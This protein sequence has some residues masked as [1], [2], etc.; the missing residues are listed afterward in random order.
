ME[1]R[2]RVDVRNQGGQVLFYKREYVQ[3]MRGLKR[4]RTP[5]ECRGIVV[6]FKSDISLDDGTES[7]TKRLQTDGNTTLRIGG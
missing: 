1:K 7:K 5:N 3:G 6:I 4:A 2:D